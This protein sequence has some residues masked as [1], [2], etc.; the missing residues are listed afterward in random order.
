MRAEY[1]KSPRD[2]TNRS[3]LK[4]FQSKRAIKLRV[5]RKVRK[6]TWNKFANSLNSG[7]PTKKIWVKFRKINENYKPIIV[8]PLDSGGNIITSPD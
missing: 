7:T 4:T 3:K 2:P 6:D 8:P 5:F 1:R